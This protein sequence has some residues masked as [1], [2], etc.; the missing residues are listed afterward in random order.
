[1]LPGIMT[2]RPL[3][4]LALFL[5]TLTACRSEG[6][7]EKPKH[8]EVPEKALQGVAR[9][10]LD[11]PEPTRAQLERRERSLSY[12]RSRSLPHLDSLP[13]V[14][15]ESTIVPRTGRE[16]AERAM[17]IAICAVKG[18]TGDHEL[19]LDLVERFKAAS[20]FSPKERRFIDEP[21]PQR[22]QL[23]DH[24]WGY[25]VLHVVLWSLG[26]VADL[27][28][29]GE[30]CDVPTEVGIVRDRGG[31]PG[32][33]SGARLRALGEVLDRADLY[34]HLHW[35]AIELRLRGER[36]EALDEGVIRERHR[37]LNWLIRYLDQAWD[38]V[39]TDT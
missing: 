3:A 13:V 38:D 7:M 12:L 4:V 10:R 17:A 25:E 2:T 20:L 9:T 26:Y 1:M 19:A 11:S 15:D 28:P 31:V 18:E 14:E 37:A 6:A 35:T 8:P 29:P 39:T 36:S 22:Q 33:A 30:I 34:Y 21:K 24:A 16:I 5:A 32:L 23:V 27:K